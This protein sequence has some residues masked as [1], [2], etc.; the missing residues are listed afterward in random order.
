MF[1]VSRKN[2]QG[3]WGLPN[4]ARIH[5]LD[6]G[7]K[8]EVLN[9]LAA[10]PLRTFMMTSLI[11]DNGL[12]TSFNRGTFYGCR[13]DQGR[14]EG[15]ALIGDITLF[16]AENDRALAAFVRLTRTC[17]TADVVLGRAER[18]DRF[19]SYYTQASV[20]PRLVCYELLLRNRSTANVETVA[21]LRPATF[22]DLELVVPVHAQLVFEEKGVNPLEVDPAGFRQRCA[23][24]V[25]QGRVWGA[26]EDGR[27]K[28]K[29]NVVSETAEVTYLEGVYVSSEHRGNGYGARCLTQLTNHLLERADSV[30]L[31]VNQ[32]NLL[33][34]ACYRKAGY[35]FQ[36][37]YDTLYL[38]HQPPPAD[39]ELQ[40]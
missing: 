29:A 33:A 9:F 17:P 27:L 36:E 3:P 39:R 34:Q 22:N 24:R 5:P 1:Q 28:F 10:H 19:L 15:V 20:K 11:N 37:Y 40:P 8:T 7:H 26:I 16:E 38:Q 18:V 14:L 2:S 4:S 21:S 35:Q 23:H 25:Q 32:K 6:N 30:C 12:V 31:L 13:A